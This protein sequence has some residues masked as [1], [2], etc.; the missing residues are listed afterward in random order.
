MNGTTSFV[1]IDGGKKVAV[2]RATIFGSGVMILNMTVQ[3]F[4]QR[5]DNHDRG[6]LIQDEN[7]FGHLTAKE[8]EFLISGMTPDVW[9]DTFGTPPKRVRAK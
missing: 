2:E 8:R 5:K 1:P 6:L 4:K 7:T 3:E 9:K